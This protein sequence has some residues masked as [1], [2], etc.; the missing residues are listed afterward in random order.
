MKVKSLI[1][2]PKK[3]GEG[4]IKDRVYNV[5]DMSNFPRQVGVMSEDC[6]GLTWLSEDYDG[7]QEFEVVEL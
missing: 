7:V 1:T 4:V 5:E 2:W 3:S 6:G